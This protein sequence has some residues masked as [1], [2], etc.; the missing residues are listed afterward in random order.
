MSNGWYATYNNFGATWGKAVGA[1]G[2]AIYQSL[3]SRAWDGQC[4]PS[5]QTIAEDTGVSRPTAIK[6]IKKL[7][8]VGLIEVQPRFNRRGDPTS[9]LY[10]L[11]NL[12]LLKKKAE[13]QTKPAF[14]E[15]DTSHLSEEEI[16]ELKRKSLFISRTKKKVR[17]PNPTVSVTTPTSEPTE[18]NVEVK[19]V[20]VQA[21][22]PTPVVQQVAE[23][24][25]LPQTPQI[26]VSTPQTQAESSSVPIQSQNTK[27]EQRIFLGEFGRI[28]SEKDIINAY[29]M[30][31]SVPN[32]QEVIDE[33]NKAIRE[34]RIQ[35]TPIQYLGGLIKKVEQGEFVPSAHKKTEDEVFREQ[36]QRAAEK[37]K[38]RKKAIAECLRCSEAGYLVYSAIEPYSPKS[39]V[40]THDE[41]AD[42]FIAKKKAEEEKGQTI[43]YFGKGKP[44]S[45]EASEKAL[46]AIQGTVAAMTGRSSSPTPKESQPTEIE[47]KSTTPPSV[48]AL[49]SEI[50]PVQPEQPGESGFKPI[51]EVINTVLVQAVDTPVQAQE[52]LKEVEESPSKAEPNN[53]A[54]EI[55]AA[56]SEATTGNDPLSQLGK[57]IVTTPEH[58]IPVPITEEQLAGFGEYSEQQKQELLAQVPEPTGKMLHPNGKLMSVVAEKIV[59]V[60]EWLEKLYAY[61]ELIT[62]PKII[63]HIRLQTVVRA[64]RLRAMIDKN[65]HFSKY[66]KDKASRFVE[67]IHHAAPTMLTV[68]YARRNRLIL[69][70]LIEIYEAPPKAPNSEPSQEILS[71]RLLDALQEMNIVKKYLAEELRRKEENDEATAP[72]DEP[73]ELQARQ[74]H[75]R[76]TKQF[77]LISMIQ[78]EI[79]EVKG[80]VVAA[81]EYMLPEWKCNPHELKWMQFLA[82]GAGLTLKMTREPTAIPPYNYNDYC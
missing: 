23:P 64:A 42:K 5:Y 76:L 25:V 46:K 79:P 24:P 74:K 20:T 9:N 32:K 21:V 2:I 50:S 22:A 54:K 60:N 13:V 27:N 43:C 19:T 45:K 31:K 75:N 62:Q 47:Q 37:E 48:T 12:P 66:F 53:I 17:Q 80:D 39:V 82:G 58:V 77:H 69:D 71:Q 7:Q 72:L 26:E 63:G 41:K 14:E 78:D 8:E 4:F 57:Q 59:I 33:L 1:V 81:N 55:N 3:A 73:G 35:T 70:K 11:A 18:Q 28:S 65:T 40:C 49:L 56:L 61:E 38:E 10:T 6:Y 29:H 67:A 36:Q 34:N 68:P 52:E 15:I 30:L 51:G 16:A 44:L